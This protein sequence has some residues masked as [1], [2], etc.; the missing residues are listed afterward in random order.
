[1][2]AE[3]FLCPSCGAPLD[4]DGGADLTITCPFCKQSVIVPE[5]LRRPAMRGFVAISEATLAEIRTLA[6]SGRV[7][8]AAIMYRN[9]TGVSMEEAEEALRR[10]TRMAPKTP[11]AALPVDADAVFRRVRDLAMAGNTLEAIKVYREAYDVGLKEAKDAVEQMEASGWMERVAPLITTPPAQNQQQVIQ[12]ILQLIQS[13][14]K[15]EA[16]KLF[17][18][19]FDV[20]LTDA[21]ASVE[22]M[23]HAGG[24]VAPLHMAPRGTEARP[25]GM[26]ASSSQA[27]RAGC[28][29]LGIVILLA[30]I[31]ALVGL[32]LAAAGLF[33]GGAAMQEAILPL[34]SPTPPEATP[35]PTQPTGY[36]IDLTFG[37]E[38]I[39]AGRFTDARWIGVDAD[40]NIYTGEYSGGRVQ[41]FDS[42]GKFITQWLVDAEMP[43][44]SLA[45]GRDGTVYIAQRGNL[46]KFEGATGA[47]LGE[48]RLPERVYVD[49]VFTLADGGLALVNSGV[50]EEILLLNPDESVRLR[51][52]EVFSANGGRR[53]LSMRVAVD[54]LG[55]IY[56]LG[57]F[58]SA[59]F[60]FNPEGTFVSRFSSEGNEPGQLRA[61]EDI[62]V[63]GEGNIYISDIHGIQVF[64]SDGRYLRTLDIDAPNVPF[65]LDFTDDDMLLISFR[66]L[67]MRIKL[68]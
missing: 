28:T 45:A 25:A 33:A 61:P 54:G 3:V 10:L 17:R 58:N 40:G 6:D 1:M 22:A 20:S 38:G 27:R 52:P 50:A 57:A 21:K 14:Q 31:G 11:S 36:T 65:G 23:E 5:T 47:A 34:L 16:I 46:Y 7:T 68:P 12:R 18:E 9:A 13:G 35:E 42:T 44:R 55:N 29:I 32:I 60:K 2:P 39:G 63:D 24:W 8:E 26:Q 59:V 64:A 56:V 43:L 48:V 19:T 4:Y 53:E 51:I 30:G 49:D 66:S 37:S 15:I 67:M 41:A 62:A